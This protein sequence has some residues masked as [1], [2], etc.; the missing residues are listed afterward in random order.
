MFLKC[1]YA[2]TKLYFRL[3]QCPHCSRG[4]SAYNKLLRSTRERLRDI[5][6]SMSVC[7]SVCLA[8]REDISGTTHAILTKICMH[9]E[10]V[11]GS[12]LFLHVYDRPHRLSQGRGFLPH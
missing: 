12:V 6:M 8:V 1:Q 3:S 9:V 2:G 4:V 7:G 5:M 11:R 10:C